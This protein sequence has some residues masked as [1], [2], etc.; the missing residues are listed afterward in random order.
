MFF[1]HRHQFR[2]IVHY[3]RVDIEAIYR[4]YSHSQILLCVCRALAC[5]QSQDGHINIM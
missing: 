2:T 1:A 5:R 3:A 4:V